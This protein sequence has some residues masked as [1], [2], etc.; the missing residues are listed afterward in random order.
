MSPNQI[1]QM[2][3][4]NSMETQNGNMGVSSKVH[5]VLPREDQQQI[6]DTT[7]GT[8]HAPDLLP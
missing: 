8:L 7:S 1:K 2:M 5:L 3:M 6:T 4:M